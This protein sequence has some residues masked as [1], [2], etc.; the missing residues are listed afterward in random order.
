MKIE[1]TVEVCNLTTLN[2]TSSYESWGYNIQHGD[3][4][5]QYCIGYLE[6]ANRLDLKS[7]HHT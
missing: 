6:V 1:E 2:Q 3:Y 7:S 5:L 4:S